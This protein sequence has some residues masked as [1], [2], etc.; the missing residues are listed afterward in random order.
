MWSLIRASTPGHVP[1]DEALARLIC[2]APNATSSGWKRSVREWR[3]VRSQLTIRGRRPL[4]K[5]RTND[6]R[7]QKAG[8]SPM[9]LSVL[10]LVRRCAMPL[11]IKAAFKARVY[12]INGLATAPLG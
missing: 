12:D 6:G 11:S 2:L 8:W 4:P 3:A 10:T 5:G 7:A 1:G 9:V